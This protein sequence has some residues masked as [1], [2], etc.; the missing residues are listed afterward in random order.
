M[1]DYMF[2]ERKSESTKGLFQKKSVSD[3]KEVVLV[4]KT[5]IAGMKF[6][7]DIST[8]EGRR[9]IEGLNPGV[10]L[11]LFREP[12]NEH[13]EWAVAVYT[14]EDVMIGYITRYKNET[15]ARLMDYGKKFYAIIDEP[16][17]DESFNENRAITESPDLRFSVYMEL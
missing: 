8:E 10:C 13:D 14:Q 3:K 2:Q 16:E 1:S 11:S 5:G 7:T 15:I 9:V 6:H 17:N 12:D 4:L